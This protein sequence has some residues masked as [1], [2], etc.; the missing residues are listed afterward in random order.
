MEDLKEEEERHI[1]E[2]LTEEELDLY[3]LLYKD[4]LTQ[5]E[6]KKVK[7]AAKT[8]YQTLNEKRNILFKVAWEKDQNTKG[9]VKA[10]ITY[11]LNTCLPECYGRDIF[12]DKCDAVFD[13]IVD[14]ARVGGNW[15]TA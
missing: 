15:V 4:K 6:E 14:L 11:V 2:G 10:E 9:Q 3:D 8:L 12:K 1:R 5:E 7:L 13:R